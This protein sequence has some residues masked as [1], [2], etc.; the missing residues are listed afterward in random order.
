[1]TILIFLRAGLETYISHFC[2][3]S[4]SQ[5]VLTFGELFKKYSAAN[6]KLSLSEIQDFTA[7]INEIAGG[8]LCLT[9]IVS[10]LTGNTFNHPEQ[11]LLLDYLLNIQG[12]LIENQL[13]FHLK[14]CSFD[15]SAALESRV[16]GADMMIDYKPYRL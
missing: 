6:G 10:I 11:S 4:S 8:E 14:I 16:I 2:S 7:R 12:Q 15:H 5:E 1:M 13:W 9:A 3:N